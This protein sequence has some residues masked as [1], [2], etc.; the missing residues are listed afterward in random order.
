MIVLG[1]QF[2]PL[3]DN[4]A[5]RRELRRGG[6]DRLGGGPVMSMAVPADRPARRFT[7]TQREILEAIRSLT[8][9]H[10]HPPCMREVLDR[11]GLKTT[12]ALSYQYGKLKDLGYLRWKPGRQ[13]TVEVR[14]PDEPPFSA[15]PGQIGPSPGGTGPAVAETHRYTRPEKVAWVPVLGRI[16]AGAP[17]LAQQQPTDDYLPLPRDVVGGEDGDLFILQVT[18]DS[19]TGVGILPGDWVVVRRLFQ[20]PKNG[21]IVVAEIDGAEAEITVKTY[22]K[23]GRDVVL[24]PQN[25]AWPAMLGNKALIRGKVVAVLRRV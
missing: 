25:P 19:M 18:S 11:V 8:V 5:A 10:Q 4:T 3:R 21:D 14:L 9:E 23:P 1:R 24:M 20:A 15:E 17:V 12:S 22:L 7:P 6:N 2:L 16:A 13:R